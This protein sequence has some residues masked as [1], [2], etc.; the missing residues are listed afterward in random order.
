VSKPSIAAVFLL[1][2]LP[3]VTVRAVE[4]ALR[5]LSADRPD[6]TESANT[7]DRGHWQV[8]TSFFDWSKDA[9]GGGETETILA[10]NLKYGLTERSDLQ[11]VMDAY[12]IEEVGPSTNRGFGD[13][14]LRYKYNLWGND[15]GRTA[16]ALLPF[17]KIPTGTAVSN[18]EWEGGLALPW[19]IDLNDRF[20]LG[21]MLE[22]DAA[23][24]DEDSR[25]ETEI[26]HTAV[27]GASLT[28][29]LSAFVEYIGVSGDFPHQSYGSGGLVFSIN[30]NL[31][32]DLGVRFGL[33]HA[34]E[35]VGLFS[36]MTA[37]F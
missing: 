6:T 31:A 14:Q 24:D 20:S 12:V 30:D 35:K 16:F 33:N 13:V 34:D 2:S 11:L 26:V 21:L 36:G 29:K 32:L 4:T 8:E 22:I 15:G 19:S 3:H 28:E 23:Y 9:H 18:G 25:H 7:V 10:A 27:L 1:A 5:E 17:V 37:R